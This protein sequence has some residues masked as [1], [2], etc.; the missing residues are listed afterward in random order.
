[1]PARMSGVE[2]VAYADREHDLHEWVAHAD[3]EHDLHEWV[4]GTDNN[5]Y[6]RKDSL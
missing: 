2:W 1:M 6:S 5:R 3:H 4:A